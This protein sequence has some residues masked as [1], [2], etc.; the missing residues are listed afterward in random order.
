MTIPLNQINETKDK[1]QKYENWI[2]LVNWK[3]SEA[4]KIIKSVVEHRIDQSSTVTKIHLNGSLHKIVI[5]QSTMQILGH[6]LKPTVKV[7]GEYEL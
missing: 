3:Y 6:Q 2:L 4:M 5:K 7:E 1:N